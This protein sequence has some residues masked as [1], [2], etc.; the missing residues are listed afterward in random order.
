MCVCIFQLKKRVNDIENIVFKW[1]KVN[2]SVDRSTLDG[3]PFWRSSI[4]F[5]CV[6]YRMLHQLIN[7]CNWLLAILF[8]TKK[9]H[10]SSLEQKETWPR[11]FHSFHPFSLI[12]R[13]IYFLFF[14]FLFWINE[15][16]YNQPIVHLKNT[17]VYH[18]IEQN[19]HIWITLNESGWSACSTYRKISSMA[20][21]IKP[22]SDD[23]VWN[24]IAVFGG[25]SDDVCGVPATLR[26]FGPSIVCVLPEIKYYTRNGIPNKNDRLNFLLCLI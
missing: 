5:D 23:C 1:G 11:A 12:I 10:F 20:F 22:P 8:L 4:W 7:T 9:K 25:N 21:T 26:G 15:I 24:D 17:V 14:S 2:F 16:E 18:E 13:Q 6:Q 19:M 3:Q